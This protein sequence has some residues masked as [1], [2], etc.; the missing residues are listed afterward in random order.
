MIA[1]R[2]FTSTCA[3]LAMAAAVMA[4]VQASAGEG[5]IELTILKAAAIVGAAGGGGV[6]RFE[7][8]KIPLVV[9]GLTVGASM[10]LAEVTLTGTAKN[11]KVPTDIVGTYTSVD[12]SAAFVLGAGASVTFTNAAGVR[13]D[14][15]GAEVGMDLS[16]DIGEF[17][18][19]IR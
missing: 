14:L 12:A 13:L 18:L 17:A 4:P 19:A 7:G 5:V 3:A 1:T 9:S 8:A 15:V 6:L 10:A 11:M 16:L 2:T